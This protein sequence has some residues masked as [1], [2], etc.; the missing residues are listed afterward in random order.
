MEK[1]VQ[2]VEGLTELEIEVLNASRKTNFGDCLES[3]QWSFAV[4]D[5]TQ[6]TEKTYRGVVSSLVK[7]E[8]VQIFDNDEKGRY[9]DMV[10]C[11]TE[12]GKKLFEEENKMTNRE[13]LNQLL[14]TLVEEKRAT[15]CELAELLKVSKDSIYSWRSSNEARWTGEKRATEAVATL[16]K[17]FPKQPKAKDLV[18]SLK[19]IKEEA[20]KAPAMDAAID[21]ITVKELADEFKLDA[22]KARRILRK[23]FGTS[24]KRWEWAKNSEELI[25]VKLVLLKD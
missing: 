2:H 5:A 25:A 19:V 15:V 22:R 9:A 3:G 23:V 17:A 10:F 1:T 16:E 11:F 13:K 24:H 8:L 6:L 20:K 14:N 18:D 21:I 4:C 7:K 12:K